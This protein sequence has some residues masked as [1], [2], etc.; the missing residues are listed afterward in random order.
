MTRVRHGDVARRASAATGSR[1]LPAPG[2]PARHW[3]TW[4]L[5]P[6]VISQ[7]ARVEVSTAVLAAAFEAG[8]LGADPVTRGM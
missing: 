6:L 8:Y 4:S 5:G 2:L 3:V 7:L 1:W